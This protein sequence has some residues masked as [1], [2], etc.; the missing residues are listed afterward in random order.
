M[1]KAGDERTLDEYFAGHEEARAL[2]DRLR[3]A[4]ASVGASEMRVTKSQVAFAAGYAFAW[5]WMPQQYLSKGAPLVLS[6][7]LPSHDPSS[8]WK[9]VVEPARGRFM[10]HLELRA[11]GDIDD[12]VLG[13][14]SEAYRFASR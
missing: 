3:D 11:P 9:Q 12:E 1:P 13:W 4:V 8:R 2:F 14:L 5:A 6:V 7:S 10:H